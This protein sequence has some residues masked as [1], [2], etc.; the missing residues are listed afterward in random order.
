MTEL[1]SYWTLWRISLNNPRGYESQKITPAQNWIE[2]KTTISEASL[3]FLDELLEMFYQTQKAN[4]KLAAIAGLCLRC[5]VSSP[6]LKACKQLANQFSGGKFFTY[7]DLLPLVL[8]DDGKSLI[9]ID[10]KQDQQVNVDINLTLTPRKFKI[11]GLDILQSYHQNSKA[12]V[13]LDNWAYLR[14]KQH[15]ELRAFLAE[16]G[17]QHLSNWALLNRIGKRQQEQLSEKDSLIINAFHEVYRRDRRQQSQ[18][19]LGKCPDPSESQLQEMMQSLELKKISFSNPLDLLKELHNIANQL[20]QYD[21]WQSRESL[22]DFD[23]ESGTYTPRKDLPH[24]SI[25]EVAIEQQEILSNLHQQLVKAFNKSL[26]KGI[27]SRISNLKKSKNYSPFVSK[28]LL[29]LRSYYVEAKS[30]K[31]IASELEISWDKARRIFN[32]GDLLSQIRTLTVQ[33]LLDYLLKLAQN[34]GLVTD[35]T[36]PNYLTNLTQQIEA[37]ADSEIFQEAASEIR[38]GK[39]RNFESPYAQTLKKYLEKHA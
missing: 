26:E 13:S 10:L 14:T 17:F 29:G 11:F 2:Q 22:E 31:D 20:R 27:E 6:I 19:K 7:K 18:R 3:Q 25:S 33:Q 36:D 39:S 21:V 28:F 30:L 35:A 23:P 12:K 37:F 8:T 1:S 34:K 4:I 15:P 5:Y 24:E 9:I 38:A 16:F 32:P